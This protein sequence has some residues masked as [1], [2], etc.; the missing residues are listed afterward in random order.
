M[1]VFVFLE[2]EGLSDGP[3]SELKELLKRYRQSM[4][5]SQLW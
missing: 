1:F 3:T 5:A 4:I 2:I